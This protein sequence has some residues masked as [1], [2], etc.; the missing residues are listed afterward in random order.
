MTVHR[1]DSQFDRSGRHIVVEPVQRA[2]IAERYS[3]YLR[4]DGPDDMSLDLVFTDDEAESLI[5]AIR[6]ARWENRV[7]HRWIRNREGGLLCER[8]GLYPVDPDDTDLDC[9]PDEARRMDA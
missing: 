2:G 3:V 5:D 7:G 9:E 8:C 1:I 6:R 4:A